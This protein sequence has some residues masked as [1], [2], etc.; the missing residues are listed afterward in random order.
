LLLDRNTSLQELENRLLDAA[1]T[2][3]Q[4][5]LSSAARLLGMTRP[6]LAYRLKKRDLYLQVTKIPRR[7][8]GSLRRG[9]SQG[10]VG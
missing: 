1:V 3:S 7:R 8:P 10:E 6:N 9:K 4:G 2:R 5:N